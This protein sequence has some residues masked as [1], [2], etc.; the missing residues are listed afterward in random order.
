MTK[1]I[2]RSI[3]LVSGL[4]LLVGLGFM[5]AVFRQYFDGQLEK[6]LRQEAEYLSLAV[7]E[8][9]EDALSSLSSQAE[10]VTLVK[11][12]GTVLFDNRADSEGMENHGDREEIREA[13][14]NGSGE[15]SRYSSTLGEKT[16]YYALR[17]EDGS[18]LRVSTTQ[19]TTAS[20]ILS[21]LQPV[22]WILIL[23]LVLAGIFASRASK[24]I[25]AP[26]NKLDLDNPELN[27]PYEEVAPLLGKIG[28]Q[29]R[30]IRRQLQDAHRQQEE[31]A[32]ITGHM[33]EGLLVIDRQ[34]G[35]LSWNASALRLLGSGE[36]QADR[37]VLSLNRSEP[38]Q[39]AVEGA[40]SGN[41][42]ESLLEVGG[43]YCRVSA[44]PV[45]DEGTVKGAVLLLVDVTETMQRENLRREFTANV[46]HELK[47]PLTS[48]SG[49]AEIL[50]DGL[51]QP[52]DIKKFAGRIFGEAQRLIVLVS[53]VIKISQLDEGSVPYETETVELSETAKSILERLSPAAEKNRVSLSVEGSAKLRTVRPILEEVLYNLCDNAV[54][55]NRRGGQ[56]TVSLRQEKDFIELSVSDT[57]IGIPAADQTRVFE[58]FYRVDKSHSK[59]IGGTGLGLSIVKHGAAYLGASLSLESS[60]GEGSVFTLRW[61]LPAEEAAAAES[62]RAE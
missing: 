12:D 39:R 40:L 17:L 16:V 3:I 32:M 57:G 21:M 55:Y 38:F 61:N 35:L 1:R 50:Q 20:I 53:D 23:M 48:I 56:V 4:V 47:T 11:A 7:Q 14:E 51:V 49:F 27:E 9:G 28:R 59:E 46:S 33:E 10:R 54:K 34:T 2:F 13:L 24:M 30:T 26:L 5:L 25:V 60:P 43:V 37:S 41:R 62:G 42:T 52:Q 19:Y 6:E 29:Q 44:N 18:V 15:S 58:R 31:F 8:G 22:L 45:L 36:P